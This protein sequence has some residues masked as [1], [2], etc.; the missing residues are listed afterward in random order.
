MIRPRRGNFISDH[1]VYVDT[2]YEDTVRDHTVHVNT[3][4]IDTLGMHT[5]YVD[6]VYMHSAP[7]GALHLDST[8]NKQ[9]R[10]TLSGGSPKG[11]NLVRLA[12]VELLIISRQLIP[13]VAVNDKMHQF[14]FIRGR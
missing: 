6:R 11:R 5:V 9:T 13:S 3:V 14:P 4:Y 2:V 7:K 8:F 1:T 10:P 12:G